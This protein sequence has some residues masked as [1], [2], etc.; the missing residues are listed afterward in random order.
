MKKEQVFSRRNFIMNTGKAGLG[1]V[2]AT[3]ALASLAHDNKPVSI[4]GGNS[5]IGWQQSP[6]GYAYKALEPAIDATTM[7]IHYSKHAATYAKSLAEAVKEEQV[8]TGSTSI[9]DLLKTISKY[10]PKM[11]NNAGGHYNHELFWKSL[12]ASGTNAPSGKLAEVITKDF[13]SF[14][15]FKNQFNEAAKTRFGSGWA[16]LVYT[17]DKKL[18]VTSTPNQDNPLMDVA[19]VKGIPVLG[20]DVWEHAYYLKYQNKRAEYI[21]AWWGVVNWD[22]VGKRFS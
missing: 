18:V 7:E 19:E 9:E 6:L 12:K 4:E 21:N 17:N 15:A 3:P 5:D 16:W 14:E 22:Y 20:L 1:F 8:N 13:G 10:S 11:R 2:L